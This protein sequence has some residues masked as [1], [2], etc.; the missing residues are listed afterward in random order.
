MRGEAT[1]GANQVKSIDCQWRARHALARTTKKRCHRSMLRR[2]SRS[3]SDVDAATQKHSGTNRAN[4][5]LLDLTALYDDVLGN[6]CGQHQLVSIHFERVVPVSSDG[7][8]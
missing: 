4:C 6:V 5:A 8:V 1:L 2:P 3:H 7:V